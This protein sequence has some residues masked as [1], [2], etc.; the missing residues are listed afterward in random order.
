MVLHSTLL[1]IRILTAAFGVTTL[2]GCQSEES[3]LRYEIISDEA[4]REVG[5][6]V[7]RFQSSSD[8]LCIVDIDMR[9]ME[10]LFSGVFPEEGSLPESED[11]QDISTF[12]PLRVVT[13]RGLDV[14][15]DQGDYSEESNLERSVNLQYIECRE[16]FSGS[17]PS[18]QSVDVKLQLD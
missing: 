6:V 15:F 10:F 11:A 4:L 12:E 7:I 16:L 14:Y 13:Q 2:V 17:A 8:P 18:F 9:R 3:A 5:D 1:N